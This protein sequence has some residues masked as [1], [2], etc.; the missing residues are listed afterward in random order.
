MSI[1][2]VRAAL[3][4]RGL[5]RLPVLSNLCSTDNELRAHRRGACGISKPLSLP[6]ADA[7]FAIVQENHTSVIRRRSGMLILAA[8]HSRDRL[9]CPTHYT[10]SPA[11]GILFRR[12]VVVLSKCPEEREA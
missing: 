10:A 12:P 1:A 11:K 9:V 6:H 3:L 2:A 7:K 5:A 4:F 8:T